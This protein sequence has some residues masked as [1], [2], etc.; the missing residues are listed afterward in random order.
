MAVD[1]N[2]QGKR[3]LDDL[4]LLT[5]GLSRVATLST[6]LSAG[7]QKVTAVTFRAREDGILV[8]LKRLADDDGHPE[9]CFAEASTFLDALLAANRALVSGKWRPDKPFGT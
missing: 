9:V 1:K 8:V 4:H 2:E 7:G 3:T 5:R 6:A